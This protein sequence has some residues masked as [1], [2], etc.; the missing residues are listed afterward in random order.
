[1]SAPSPQGRAP[2]PPIGSL[3]AVLGPFDATMIVM[4]SVIGAGVFR[5]PAQ[6]AAAVGSAEAILLLWLVGGG[7]ALSGALVFAELGGSLPRAG[8]Q[9]VFVR[10]AFGRFPAFLLGWVLLTAINSSAI[11]FVAGVFAE[12]LERLLALAAPEIEFGSAGRKGVALALIALLTALNARGVRL[13]A[14]VQNVSMLAKI[15]GLILISLLAAGVALGVLE[16]EP[17]AAPP[18]PVDG[19]T[20]SGA[21]AALLSVVFAYGGFQ[22]VASVAG[23]IRRPERNLPGA[24]LIGTLG[25]TVLYLALN[26]SLLAILGVERVASSQTPVA[27]AAGAVV[28]FGEPLVAA[29]V[30]LS[31]FA[32]C[33][34]MLMALPRLYYAMAL[35]GVFLRAAASVHPRFG[36]PHVAILTLGVFAGIYVVLGDRLQELLEV[37]TLC[38]WVFFALCAL[39]LFVLRRRR[40]DMPRPFRAPGYP[41][42]PGLFLVS[43]LGVV[44][45]ALWNAQPRPVVLG[46]CLFA[47]GGILYAVWSRT[48]AR[49]GAP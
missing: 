36:T 20:W 32:A 11:A 46:L 5:V 17:P 30:M 23:E 48:A 4:G 16:S 6:I 38:D 39:A 47:A 25:V 45:N 31:T 14:V 37:C 41:W 7:V 40:P 27:A 3:Q 19:F 21:G 15:A 26:A 13:G 33:Q 28:S 34:V 12:H 29:L 2:G 10:E 1:M 24:I 9:Y 18:A 8:G 49:A 22:S 42:L 35:D 44:A 43:A